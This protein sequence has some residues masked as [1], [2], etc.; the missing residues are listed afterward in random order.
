MW[1]LERGGHSIEGS[2]K[3]GTT[4]YRSGEEGGGRLLWGILK[5]NIMN[6]PLV[7]SVLNL[8]IGL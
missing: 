7:I 5:V 4:E 3:R 6:S 8:L 2:F 1:S